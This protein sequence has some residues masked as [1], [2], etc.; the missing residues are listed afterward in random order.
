M[1]LFS[2]IT[3]AIS[4]AIKKITSTPSKVISTVT[5]APAK[6]VSKV[7]STISSAGESA[8]KSL[9]KAVSTA[10]SKAK[11]EASKKTSSSTSSSSKSSSSSRSSGSSSSK[12]S[13]TTVSQ[14]VVTKTVSAASSSR[15]GV[16][17]GTISQP[18]KAQ[19]T[20]P[21]TTQQPTSLIGKVKER[22][23]SRLQMIKEFNKKDEK[24]EKKPISF[25]FTRKEG[26]R[27]LNPARFVVAPVELGMSISDASFKAGDFLADVVKGKKKITDPFPKTGAQ[28]LDVGK[29]AVTG[30]VTKIQED[31]IGFV[32]ET[33]ALSAI[34]GGTKELIRPTK[35]TFTK[36]TKVITAASKKSITTGAKGTLNV[37]KGLIKR[38]TTKYAFQ[39]KGTFS[40]V[41]TTKQIPQLSK[42]KALVEALKKGTP[43][44]KST[45]E[46]FAGKIKTNIISPKNQV[47]KSVT[48][49]A[50]IFKKGATQLLKVGDETFLLK[51]T[52]T[53]TP[54]ALNIKPL[55]KGLTL[56]KGESGLF[57]L[58]KDIPSTKTV[59]KSLKTGKQTV[60]YTQPA[61]I[62]IKSKYPVVG[63]APTKVLQNVQKGFTLP[64][65][66][67]S[68]KIKATKPKIVTTSAKVVPPSLRA[69]YPKLT[70][71]KL[72]L[73]SSIKTTTPF[74][75]PSTTKSF[76]T[77]VTKPVST[78]KPFVI[79]GSK[80]IFA[81]KL[82]TVS[83]SK[84]TPKFSQITKQ[85]TKPKTAFKS[86]TSTKGLQSLFAKPL[87]AAIPVVDTSIASGV[88]K[89]LFS[90]KFVLV[91]SIRIAP[92]TTQ[93]GQTSKQQEDQ[94]VTPIIIEDIKQDEDTTT[95]TTTKTTTTGKTKKKGTTV[96]PDVPTT[97]I[98]EP[99]P[100]L[101]VIID[102]RPKEKPLLK[103]RTQRKDKKKPIATQYN[104]F[105][106]R[107]GKARKIN[108]TPLG[109]KR[110][111]NFG[112]ERV[113]RTLARSFEVRPAMSNQ[114]PKK[115]VETSFKFRMRRTRNALI[116]V[117]KSKYAFDSPTERKELKV[118]RRIF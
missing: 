99:R 25:A 56:I 3:S 44:S 28:L 20:E 62:G 113:D 61:K 94:T 21:I 40:K 86:A 34:A 16:T 97:V 64:K 1:G 43:S 9:S 37:E 85:L 107:Q 24:E 91:P 57:G 18:T 75:P 41:P 109:L 89:N 80:S 59:S 38:T 22:I 71:S 76:V 13:P 10:V 47:L 60:S 65:T 42:S 35:V 115:N 15:S 49:Q 45:V 88:F 79:K 19:I 74:K 106:R 81:Q 66:I 101:P 46:V 116:F 83:I 33:I 48:Q 96:I 117:E 90:T 93:Q 27:Q 58:D 14:P 12:S 77:K 108:A 103:P 55:G 69:P 36:P 53:K 39:Q 72:K 68:S 23:S 51:G 7:T 17:T 32:S 67:K 95:K 102:T 29:R 105:V 26:T 63:K 8:S 11:S 70:S 73:P 54:T 87:K 92:K 104:V 84:Q 4:S 5:S 2:S 78:S 6:A 50:T 112:S 98:T 30:T 100:L 118:N 111:V 82:K 114:Q 31:P 52:I 110:A